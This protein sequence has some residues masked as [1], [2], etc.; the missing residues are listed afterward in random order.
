MSTFNRYALPNLLGGLVSPGLEGLAALVE[1][2]QPRKVVQTHDEP[3]HAKG[4]VP[5]L[6]RIV[7]FDPSRVG[8]HPWL[9]DRFL[10]IS[11]Y[12]PVNP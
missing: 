8:D 3:K 5:A 11:D 1:Q 2:T 12:T 4:V 10:D 6:A 7:P 9:R